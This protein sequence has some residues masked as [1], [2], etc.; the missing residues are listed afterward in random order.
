MLVMTTMMMTIK[1]L[2]H[3]AGTYGLGELTAGKVDYGSE[4]PME[5]D[6]AVLSSAFYIDWDTPTTPQYNRGGKCML[7]LLGVYSV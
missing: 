1:F 6:D 2:T 4:T 5:R 7:S 3:K